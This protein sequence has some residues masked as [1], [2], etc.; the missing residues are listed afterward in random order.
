MGSVIIGFAL[1]G[2][3]QGHTAML[4]HGKVSTNFFL[5]TLMFENIYD[6][7]STSESFD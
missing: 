5:L 7:L 4:L 2:G 3:C 6:F 1:V